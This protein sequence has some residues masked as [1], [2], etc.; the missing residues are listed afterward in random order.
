MKLPLVAIEGK[1]DTLPVVAIEP[2]IVQGVTKD[3]RIVGLHLLGVKSSR[4]VMRKPNRGL[5]GCVSKKQKHT[6]AQTR[7]RKCIEKNPRARHVIEV[8]RSIYEAQQA[9]IIT[10]VARE[11]NGLLL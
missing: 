6:G 2:A 11:N 8:C 5:F 9:F 4:R 1:P 10:C 3:G 7:V